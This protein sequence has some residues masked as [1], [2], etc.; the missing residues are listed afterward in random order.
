MGKVQ[1]R[2]EEEDG[3]YRRTGKLQTLL[4]LNKVR[5]IPNFWFVAIKEDRPFLPRFYKII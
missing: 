4:Q 3:M 2:L 5:G 1:L